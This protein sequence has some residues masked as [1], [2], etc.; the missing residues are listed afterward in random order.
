MDDVDRIIERARH[1]AA[2]G[3]GDRLLSRVLPVLDALCRGGLSY[4]MDWY[5]PAV[6]TDAADAGGKLGSAEL[7]ELLTEAAHIAR[8][9]RGRR[10][11]EAIASYD[12]RYQTDTIDHM[13]RT[14]VAHRW[15]ERPTSFVR[16]PASTTGPGPRAGP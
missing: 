16:A 12:R 14:A 2:D 7:A 8:T 15:R 1:H 4:A 11:H 6:F 10:L 13:L 3:A 5:R 9:C